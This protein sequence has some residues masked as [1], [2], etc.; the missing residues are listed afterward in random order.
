MPFQPGNQLGR[1]QGRKG[2]EL[3]EAERR[4]LKALL[5]I[6]INLG[7]K[8]AKGTASIKEQMAYGNIEKLILKILDK[9]AATK[10]QE[11]GKLEL[12]V[13]QTI[14]LDEKTQKLVEDFIKWRKQSL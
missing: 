13:N 14:E 12:E 11:D 3:E 1:N 6:G 5:K 2:F 10:T 8:M 4:K 7:M 9:F